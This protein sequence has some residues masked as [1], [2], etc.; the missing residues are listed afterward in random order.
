MI[1]I[2]TVFFSCQ[3][4]SKVDPVLGPY[5]R[6]EALHI[7][8]EAPNQVNFIF[9]VKDKDYFAVADKELKDFIFYEE[10][11]K[12][13]TPLHIA[14]DKVPFTQKTVILIDV[15]ANAEGDFVE[16]K[17]AVENIINNKQDYQEIAIY[18]FGDNIVSMHSFSDNKESLI[19]SLENI[20][21][22][23]NSRKV[24]D[25]VFAVSKMY[26]NYYGMDKIVEGNTIVFTSGDDTGSTSSLNKT[27][28]EVND[29]ENP[30]KQK[31]IFIIGQTSKIDVRDFEFIG[32]VY[33]ADNIGN[34]S[35][36]SQEIG[37]Y[38][39]KCARSIYGI[40]YKTEKRG[41][42]TVPVRAEIIR[43]DNRSSSSYAEDNFLSTNLSG[44]SYSK[45][46]YPF[47][48]N[49]E[50]N[51]S[52][53]IELSWSC[54][55]PED[56]TLLYDVFMKKEDDEEDHLMIAQD[57]VDNFYSPTDLEFSNTYNWYV[58][59]RTPGSSVG[60]GLESERWKF[61]TMF[62]IYW[63]NQNSGVHNTLYGVDFLN[64]TVGIAVGSSLQSGGGVILRT[65]DAG[66]S[67]NAHNI[68]DDKNLNAVCWQ[69]SQSVWVVGEGGMLLKSVDAGN[70]WEKIE[71]LNTESNLNDIYFADENNAWIVGSGGNIFVTIDGGDNWNN[72]N[73]NVNLNAVSYNGE[74]TFIVGDNGKIFK[75]FSPNEWTE[76]SNDAGDNILKGISF[77]SVNIGFAV[78][79]SSTILKTENAGTSWDTLYIENLT[80]DL[81]LHDI[82]AIND[83][84]VYF[85]GDG[86]Q[87]WFSKNGGES[88]EF[89]HLNLGT[90]VSLRSIDM[91]NENLAW[92]VGADGKIWKYEFSQ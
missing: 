89:K 56:L 19:S 3:K 63:I 60:T 7:S 22:S 2:V 86:G 72:Y 49:E 52:T 64:E 41:N 25:A 58:V 66:E 62:S 81:S 65:T 44:G 46:L 33:D 67:W 21:F 4:D 79:A 37:E 32:K 9:N 76:I 77:S 68:S 91:I 28:T 39:K 54:N 34:L 92:I 84:V 38:L 50:E 29:N 35:D 14:K 11:A 13:I 45:P 55:N 78:G 70:T 27:S 31:N 40:F 51:V 30:S 47:P 57:L 12:I 16:V 90:A 42:Y 36:K 8:A 82:F 6:L 87:V 5:F 85:V 59:A 17:K 73:K 83:N 26:D 61:E 1:F 74:K 71:N 80:E 15:S 75:E 24:Y 69:N 18:T 88:W 10:S 23:G 48:E 20:F 53:N 43:N